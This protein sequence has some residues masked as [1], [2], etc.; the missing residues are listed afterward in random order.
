MNFINTSSVNNGLKADTEKYIAR[1]ENIYLSQIKETAEKI[2]ADRTDKP[3]VLIS[4]PSGSGKTTSALKIASVIREKGIKVKTV[5][6]DNYFLPSDMGELPV[7]ENGNIDLEAPERLDIKL[8]SDDLKKISE[9]QPIEIP[10]FDFTTQLRSGCIPMQREKD[11]IVIIEGI[12][13]L[14]PAVTGNAAENFSNGIYISVRTRIISE[15]DVTLHP[16]VIRLMR[17]LCRDRLFRGRE[18]PDI[19]EMFVSVSRG[20]DLYIMPYKHRASMDIDTFI[21]YE[22]S[23]YSELLLSDLKAVEGIMNNSENYRQTE[24]FLSEMIPLSGSIVPEASL[25]REFIGGGSF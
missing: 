11:E 25:I 3:I 15:D 18:L 6:M 22:L 21:P 2:C 9:C 23:V 5:S 12:H 10:I 20:E 19:F 8:F 13:A 14:N 16:S 1:S 7:D 24:K 4:G 17:R